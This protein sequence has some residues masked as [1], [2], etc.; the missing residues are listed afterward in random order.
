MLRECLRAAWAQV[1]EVC[2]IDNASQPPVND[3]TPYMHALIRDEEQPP[4]LARLMNVGF[5]WAAR[6]ALE[7]GYEEWN[8]AVLCDDVVIPASW[9]RS[10]VWALRTTNA[11]AG[12]THQLQSVTEPIIKTAPDT[13]IVNR[14]QGSACVFKG[15]LGLRA[16]ERM[17]W[18]W[19]DTDLDWQARVGGGMIIAPGPVAHNSLPNDFTYSVPGLAEQAGRDGEV[20][21][22]KWGF[23]P[24]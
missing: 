14:M 20:F 5:D 6:R 15:E 16:D 13:D 12:S 21:A 1:D 18:W 4:N 11:A 19:Q 7:L 17:H 23:K 8:V 9:F 24:W 3:N 10:V 2:V 22:A